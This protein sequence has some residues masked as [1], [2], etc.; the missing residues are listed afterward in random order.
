MGLSPAHSGSITFEGAEIRSK[1][2]HYIAQ[3][4]LGYVPD[5]R[6]IFPDL[7]VRENL[8]V[9]M[10]KSNDP[11]H[12]W[13]MDRVYSL[14][15]KL[16]T[17]ES[18]K[19]GH[20]SGGEQQM[21]AIGRALMTNP[22]LLLLDEPGEGLSPLVVKALGEQI[23]VLKE[24][25]MTLVVSEQNMKFAMELSDRAYVIEKGM[26]RY[27]GSIHDFTK[28]NWVKEKYLMV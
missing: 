14:F 19:G 1:P 5:D 28:N 17:L 12:G 9:A 24:E 15:P 27:Q 22:K 21:L 3:L 7:T 18:N 26:I 10:K 16:R 2:A 20:L 6:R 25:G 4:G 23:R 11:Q 13:T 8:L